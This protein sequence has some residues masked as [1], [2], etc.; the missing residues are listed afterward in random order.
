MKP[1]TPTNPQH[2]RS[3][4]RRRLANAAVS[5]VYLTYAAYKR[6]SDWRTP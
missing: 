2:I 6:V 1:Y 4:H 3:K 5:R